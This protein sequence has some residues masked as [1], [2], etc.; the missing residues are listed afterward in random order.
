[1]SPGACTPVCIFHRGRER[2]RQPALRSADFVTVPL[3]W[4][5]VPWHSKVRSSRF[6]LISKI[7]FLKPK[8]WIVVCFDRTYDTL[9]HSSSS[10]NRP[11]WNIYNP[12]THFLWNA[13]GISP[14]SQFWRKN[15]KNNIK[16]EEKITEKSFTFNFMILERRKEFKWLW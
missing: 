4:I 3:G 14:K 1:M 6:I 13:I 8:R 11:I 9:E 7:S 15:M 10:N 16:C 2:S 12:V 5:Q